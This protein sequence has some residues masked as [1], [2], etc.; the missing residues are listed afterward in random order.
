MSADLCQLVS[1]LRLEDVYIVGR[2][3]GGMVRIAVVSLY[4]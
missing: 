3:I 4:F 2:D 1:A